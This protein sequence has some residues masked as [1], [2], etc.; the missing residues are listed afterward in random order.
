MFPFMRRNATKSRHGK[1]SSARL[2]I[3]QLEER[4]VPTA[5]AFSTGLPDGR[6]ATASR[7]ALAGHAEIESADDFILS[8]ETV[9][10]QATFTGLLPKNFSP[11]DVRDVRVEIYRVFPFDSNTTRTP[12]VPTRVNSPSDV[13]FTDRDTASGNLRFS[14]DFLNPNFTAANSVI[15][16]IH[17]APFQTTHGEGA[18]TGKEVR[19]DVTFSTPFDLPAGHYFIVPQVGLQR[20]NFLWLSAPSK[21]FSGDLQEW[22]RNDA[23]QPD[24]LRVGTD[25]VGGATPPTFDAS[26]SLAGHTVTPTFTFSTGSPDGRM[27]TASRPASHGKAEIESADDFILSSR[28][29]LTQATFTGLLP[30]GFSPSDIKDVRVEIYRVFPFDSNLKRIPRVP[31]RVNSPSDVAFADRESAAGDLDFGFE[32]LAPS[33]T[34][35]NSVVN[36]IHPKPNQT[37]GGEGPVT[38]AEV[39]F[40]VAFS[41]PL[42]LPAGHYFFVP[43]V[44]LKSGNFLWL[45]APPKQFSG[46]LQEWIRNDALQPDWL[47]VGTDVV[48]GANP[49]TFDAAFS[50]SGRAPSPV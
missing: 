5:F 7:P 33:F 21:Q 15:N 49:A 43:Q 31:T 4:A 9:L 50:L 46:D 47:R 45:S 29:Q 35:A 8:S 3:E 38:G 13:E 27:A 36:G 37:T 23:L 40:D 2:R 26:F 17:A 22:I 39:K 42:N 24:W 20:G 14:L 28:T 41:K 16:G 44:E 10:T 30:K 32:V 34:A 18:V 19:F 11:S 25:I 1:A 6:M 12:H 48:G